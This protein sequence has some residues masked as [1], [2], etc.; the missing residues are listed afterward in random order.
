MCIA[1]TGNVNIN[2]EAVS[3]LSSAHQLNNN[4]STLECFINGGA[5]DDR[6]V[7]C[8]ISSRYHHNGRGSIVVVEATATTNEGKCIS[9]I[10]EF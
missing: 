3:A 10:L 8:S 9:S 4:Y 5:S 1:N 7:K 6:A 2:T